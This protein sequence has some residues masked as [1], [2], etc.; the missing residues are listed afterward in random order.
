[1]EWEPGNQCSDSR[2]SVWSE[3]IKYA[4]RNLEGPEPFT[5]LNK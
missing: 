2:F 3:L 5:E 1:M 4:I